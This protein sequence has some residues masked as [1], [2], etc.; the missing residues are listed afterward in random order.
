MKMVSID[1]LV[2]LQ[3]RILEYSCAVSSTLSLWRFCAA[4]MELS[5]CDQDLRC[6]R[7]QILSGSLQ[8]KVASRCHIFIKQMWPRVS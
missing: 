3:E 5:R 7:S 2:C 4:A 6:L 1:L 8:K